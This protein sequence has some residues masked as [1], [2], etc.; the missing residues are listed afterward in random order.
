MARYVSRRIL[1]AHLATMKRIGAS[2]DVLPCESSILGLKFWDKAFALLKERKAPSISPRRARTPAA[3][4]CAWR[5]RRTRRRS[6][7]APTAR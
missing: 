6:S 3:G 4:S 2:Y 7:S 5:T 1:R